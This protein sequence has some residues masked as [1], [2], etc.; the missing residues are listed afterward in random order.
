MLILCIC[1][2]FYNKAGFLF[3]P[4]SVING[5]GDQSAR[6]MPSL[7]VTP[8]M[9]DHIQYSI[10]S[11][12]TAL[13]GSQKHSYHPLYCWPSFTFKKPK[14]TFSRSTL[15]FFRIYHLISPYDPYNFHCL[16]ILIRW[17]QYTDTFESRNNTLRVDFCFNSSLKAGHP[18]KQR[19]TECPSDIRQHTP[20]AHH[21]GELP[22]PGT[23]MSFRQ[24]PI[25]DHSK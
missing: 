14:G 19:L 6:L 10:N 25:W 20:T 2:N 24:P 21:P 7:K 15:G 4:V 3:F 23:S 5:P 17:N 18:R 8:S 13:Y 1:L 22:V 11:D 12:D 9:I 16:T